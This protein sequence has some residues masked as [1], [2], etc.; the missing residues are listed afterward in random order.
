MGRQSLLKLLTLTGMLIVFL[1]QFSF[2][3]QMAPFSQVIV[4]TSTPTP[5]PASPGTH[6]K[7][8]YYFPNILMN[9]DSITPNLAPICS[10]WARLPFLRLKVQ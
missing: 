6:A 8:A 4:P 7:K 1:L 9:S 3:A 2:V 5:S 10:G